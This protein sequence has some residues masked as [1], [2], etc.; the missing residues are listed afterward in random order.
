MTAKPAQNVR[1]SDKPRGKPFQSGPDPRR[2]KSG[3][4]PPNELSITHWLNEFGNKT[5]GALAK[6]MEQYAKELKKVKGEMTMFAHIAIRA[7]MGQINE[8]SPG[9]LAL[10]LE[11]TEG[12]VTQPIDVNWREELEKQGVNPATAFDAM[13]RAAAEALGKHESE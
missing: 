5:P 10:I 8:P 13:V 9:L 1:K 4:R 3:G 2:G 6:D 7:L 12:K 11:R